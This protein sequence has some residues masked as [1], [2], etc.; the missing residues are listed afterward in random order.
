VREAVPTLVCPRLLAARSLLALLAPANAPEVDGWGRFA[1]WEVGGVEGWVACVGLDAGAF[2]AVGREDCVV[3]G[4]GLVPP[5]WPKP[6]SP[7]GFLAGGLTEFRRSL[8]AA[9]GLRGGIVD[10]PPCVELPALLP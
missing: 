1:C 3:G 10:A 5:A 8:E 4:V 9:F 6:R 2:P 7:D